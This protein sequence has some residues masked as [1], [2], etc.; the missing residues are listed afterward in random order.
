MENQIAEL[1][2]L[3]DSEVEEY[4][5][6]EILL[7]E[8]KEILS[9]AK[10]DELMDVDLRLLDVIQNISNVSI[11]RENVSKSMNLG[12]CSISEIIKYL[13]EKSF[14]E[15]IIRRFE[16][17][18]SLIRNLSERISELEKINKELTEHGI[19]FSNKTLEL[20]LKGITVSNQEYNEH[21]K[22]IPSEPLDF[23]SIVEEA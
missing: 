16:E 14:D 10:S 1:E 8:K 5:K 2:N 9:N 4:K 11:K 6:V 23:S 19:E 17:K 22:S 12:I 3:I 18:Q 7:T 13:K 20:I 21:G 15:A